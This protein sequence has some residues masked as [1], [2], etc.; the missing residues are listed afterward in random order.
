MIQ[1]HNTS[2]HTGCHVDPVT[3]QADPSRLSDASI[4]YLLVSGMGCP[5]C[6]MRVHN[7]LLQLDG[8][9]AVNVA[10][11]RG[12]AQVHYDAK[13]VGPDHMPAAVD[14]AGQDGRHHYGAQ[15]LAV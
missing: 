10:L 6:A 14:A 3:K 1:L 7:A 11:E 15:V 5:A 4:A 13:V 2:T 12:V 9:L 8:V